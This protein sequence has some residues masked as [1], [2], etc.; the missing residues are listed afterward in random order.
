MQ[1]ATFFGLGDGEIRLL[2][3][4]CSFSQPKDWEAGRVPLIGATNLELERRLGWEQ[5]KVQRGLLAL[6]IAGLIA[7]PSNPSGHRR[8]V[9]GDDGHIVPDKSSGITLALLAVRHAEFV[10]MIAES[11]GVLAER[12]ALNRQIGIHF[13]AV[14]NVAGAVEVA[15]HTDQAAGFQ[16]LVDRADALM[17]GHSIRQPIAELHERLLGMASLAAQ[18]ETFWNSL[19]QAGFKPENMSSTD[20][21]HDAPYRTTDSSEDLCRTEAKQQARNRGPDLS[22]PKPS[23]ETWNNYPKDC[24]DLGDPEIASIALPELGW[25]EAD[26]ENGTRGDFVAAVRQQA[27]RY[28]ISQSL[29]DEAI[30]VLGFTGLIIAFVYI[31]DKRRNGQC[32]SP[33]GY[34]RFMINR[35]TAGKLDLRANFNALRRK[36]DLQPVGERLASDSAIRRRDR[37]ATR[38]LPS[39][40]ETG[41]D[42]TASDLQRAHRAWEETA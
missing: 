35:Y 21:I 33:G 19:P 11:R 10:A 6:R 34:L 12:R 37:T 17:H 20:D 22:Q 5:R 39:R 38:S 26:N 29:L 25:P 31:V 16:S 18:I 23:P 28:E 1:A 4:L 8:I 9:R 2:D 41:A 27:R 15:G 30:A 42:S 24:S 14:H 36:R 40:Q 32:H 7:G 13:A 3:A